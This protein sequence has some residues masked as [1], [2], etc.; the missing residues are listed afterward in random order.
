MSSYGISEIKKELL[1]NGI[2][3]I[4]NLNTQQPIISINIFLKMGSIYEP[5]KFYGIS[6][7][8]QATIIKGTKTRTA[9]QI[10]EEI[11]LL[12]G[13]ISS[14]SDDDYSTLSVV[15]GS[16]YFEKALEIL[17][18]IFYNPIFPEEEV[19]REKSIMIA[20]ILS[21]KDKIFNIAIDELMYNLYGKNHPYGIKPINFVSTIKK[22]K[23][24]NLLEWWE[25]FYGIDNGNIIVV[26]SGNLDY[27]NAK[28][29]FL[30]YFPNVKTTKLPT[31][32]NYKPQP[33]YKNIKKKTKFKQGY[34]MYGYLAP[35]LRKE[36]L[37]E[38]LSLKLLNTYLSGGM[39]SKLFYV[40]REKNSLCYETSS[41]YPTKILDSHF[42]IYLGF[43]YKRVEI[44]KREIENIIS[45]IS[46]GSSMSKSDLDEAKSKIKGRFLLDHQTNLRQGWYLG[47]W[48][49][50]GL[51]CEY[52]KKYI[53][54]IEKITLEDV[55][56]TAKK[57]FGSKNVV[58][59]LIP[60]K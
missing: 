42:V 5:P 32:T 55:K 43:D 53:E 20:D 3:F 47:F 9:K 49:I 16:R 17:S 7:L 41:F 56:I 40:L 51:G 27:E 12:G 44:A 24:N 52:D 21:R 28:E 6:E 48:E 23:R 54:D 35:S 4:H 31:V 59:E 46:N 29:I 39:S 14:N 1:S 36:N 13:S 33:N 18:D 19:E 50:M 22:L 30:K 34:L 26:V 8:L 38:Y 57:I 15:V 58:V 10:A 60:K 2:I 11:E 45:E 25:K 37:K